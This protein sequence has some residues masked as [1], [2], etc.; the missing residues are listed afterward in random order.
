ML[1]FTI[2]ICTADQSLTDFDPVAQQPII[3]NIRWN[4]TGAPLSLQPARLTMS[5]SVASTTA[6]VQATTSLTGSTSTNAV[7]SDGKVVERYQIIKKQERSSMF[8]EADEQRRVE[9]DR[10]RLQQALEAQAAAVCGDKPPG[11]DQF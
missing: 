9:S 1:S 5:V 4:G 3:E 10:V 8:M 11:K 6:S 7:G 2:R